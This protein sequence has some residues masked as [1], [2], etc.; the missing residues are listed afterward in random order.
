MRWIGTIRS[1]AEVETRIEHVESS[2]WCS[3]QSRGASSRS[4]CTRQVVSSPWRTLSASV[5]G[6]IASPRSDSYAT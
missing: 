6:E 5:P 4:A 1:K 2:T 3:R